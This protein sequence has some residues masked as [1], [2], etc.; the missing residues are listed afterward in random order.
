MMVLLYFEPNENHELL[1]EAGIIINDNN[2]YLIYHW[3]EIKK[4]ISLVLNTVLVLRFA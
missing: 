3:K 2:I 1:L 4:L